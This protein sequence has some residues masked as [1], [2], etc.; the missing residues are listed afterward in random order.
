MEATLHALG[1]ILLRAI[2]TFFLLILLHFY[3]KFVFFRP[4]GKVL[5]QRYEATEGARKLA[6]QSLE[7]AAA[8]AAEY[9]AALR[10]ARAEVYEAQERL[11]K[12]LQEQHESELRNARKQAD[13]TVEQARA[14]LAK[15]VEAAK[16]NLSRESELL[17]NQIVEAILR[18][19]AA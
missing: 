2:P 19:R 9:E 13:A 5:H 1:Q 3:L 11:H 17:A 12:Q 15:E 10:K 18:G 16:D 7:R 14:E 8:K 6:E 4:M